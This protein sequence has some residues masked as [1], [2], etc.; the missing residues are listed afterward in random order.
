M[1]T[2][3]HSA[4]WRQRV[5]EGRVRATLGFSP[6]NL[7]NNSCRTRTI[8]SPFRSPAPRSYLRPV[9]P[10]RQQENERWRLPLASAGKNLRREGRER[11]CC[12]A[13]G[14][15]IS[16]L[17]QSLRHSPGADQSVGQSLSTQDREGQ[18][19]TSLVQRPTPDD[20]F[21]VAPSS[22]ASSACSSCRSTHAASPSVKRP[23]CSAAVVL[24]GL[25]PAAV[26][27]Q[28]GRRGENVVRA[29]R[30]KLV[31]N[32]SRPT[33]CRSCAISLYLPALQ[34]EGERE[35]EM[36]ALN[37]GCRNW[38]GLY[39]HEAVIS[40]VLSIQ[41]LTIS[42]SKRWQKLTTRHTTI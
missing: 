26:W 38:T 18:G 24:D 6:R 25:V 15:D 42:R 29:R 5:P 10:A 23:P 9:R 3:K 1:S 13:S 28:V 32:R 39:C 4:R 12:L 31:G 35:R 16:L 2:W 20:D 40:F 37:P 21:D 14:P 7:T 30:T 34:L 27:P 17:L 11:C 19:L 22:S 41:L 33:V 36:V 8:S